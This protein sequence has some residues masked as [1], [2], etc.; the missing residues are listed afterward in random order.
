MTTPEKIAALRLYRSDNVGPKTYR[1]LIK[2]FGSAT[3]A[4]ERLPEMAKRGGAKKLTVYPAEKAQSEVSALTDMGGQ[5]L[6]LGQDDFPSLLAEVSDAP[7]VISVI[8][9]THLLTKPTIGIVGARNSSLTALKFAEKIAGDL[10]AQGYVVVS[11]L[12]RGIDSKAHVGS[13]ATGTVA[14]VANGL[15]IVYP[16]ENHD[17]QKQIGE[18]GLL[19]SEYPLGL[20]PQARQFPARNRIIAGLSQGVIVIEAAEGSGSL[21]TANYAAD[22]GRDVFAVP[23]SP[24]DPRCKGSNRLIKQGANLIESA[25]DVIDHLTLFERKLKSDEIKNIYG[26]DDWQQVSFSDDDYHKARQLIEELLGS[27]P[28]TTDELL[29]HAR[30]PI[31]LVMTILLEFELAGRLERL[32][33]QKISL[34]YSS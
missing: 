21:I 6:V 31:S 24:M 32:Q 33:G 23:G 22:Q 34:I 29:R 4:L 15:D 28:I 8:G 11:G 12:A 18:R 25:A 7:P 9:H 1:D 30:L 17:L 10:G 2:L 16:P 3:K 5:L 26:S 13:L 19:V 27:A 14:V 20:S